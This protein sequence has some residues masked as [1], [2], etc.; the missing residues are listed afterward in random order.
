V[1]E[2]LLLRLLL[3]A[4]VI[5]TSAAFAPF[6]VVLKVLEGVYVATTI[7]AACLKQAWTEDPRRFTRP[8]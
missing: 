1:V 2:R 4:I 5:A 8:R 6:M 3:S 7:T